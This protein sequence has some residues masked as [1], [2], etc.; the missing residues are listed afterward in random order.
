V[1]SKVQNTS[2]SRIAQPTMEP[3]V[4]DLTVLTE[5]VGYIVKSSL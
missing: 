5:L 1:P 3:V 4:A 2:A